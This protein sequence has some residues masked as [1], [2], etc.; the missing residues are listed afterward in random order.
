MKLDK[1]W[2]LSPV[3]CAYIRSRDGFFF[4][5]K[6][7]NL[8]KAGPNTTLIPIPEEESEFKKRNDWHNWGS[9]EAVERAKAAQKK[10]R[11]PKKTKKKAVKTR[12]TAVK[13][14]AVKKEKGKK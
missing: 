13:A 4:W 10:K 1:A 2:K 11:K 3:D 5:N 8:C 7:K 12:P 9:Y 14:R 6:S